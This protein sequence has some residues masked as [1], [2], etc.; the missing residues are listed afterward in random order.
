MFWCGK[1]SKCAFI[2]LALTPHIDR[3]AL[4]KLFNNK[5]L[6]LDNNL[7]PTYRQLL[8]IEGDKPLDCVGEIK[9]SRAA[10]QLAKAKYPELSKFEFELPENYNYR[11][12][13]QHSMPEGAFA[14]LKQFIELNQLPTS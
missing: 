1:C 6:L 10:M 14:L 2:F 9:E 3:S 5:N 7:E 13:S 8:G 4:E 11:T 12:L